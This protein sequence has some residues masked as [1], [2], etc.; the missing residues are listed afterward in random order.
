[1]I[2]NSSIQTRFYDRQPLR[3]G[4]RRCAELAI[5]AYRMAGFAL[6]DEARCELRVGAARRSMRPTHVSRETRASRLVGLHAQRQTRCPHRDQAWDTPPR[7][8]DRR[9]SSPRSSARDPS[10]RRGPIADLGLVLRRDRSDGRRALELTVGPYISVGCAGRTWS[11]SGVVWTIAI[12][13][14]T[15]LVWAFVG[16][17]V[18]RP[19]QSPARLDRHSR[20]VIVGGAAAAIAHRSRGALVRPDRRRPDPER[21]V[22]MILVGAPS[23]SLGSRGRSQDPH[24]HRSC[25]APSAT[26]SVAML[27][28]PTRRRAAR[29]AHRREERVDRVNGTAT[30]TAVAAPSRLRF[31]ALG[32]AGRHRSGRADGSAV[33]PPG[34]RRTQYAAL[35]AGNRTTLEASCRRAASSTTA[36]GRRSSRTSRSA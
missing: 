28:G 22:Q 5:A 20:S 29:P 2:T 31:L 12:G 30:S 24:R 17:L 14:E 10:A 1:M 23:A 4:S 36:T 9:T 13:L 7:R 15:G 18:R 16:G 8:R 3:R 34:R 19:A 6:A 25:H 21:R 26:P 33:R 27:V 11:A 32:L 35:A